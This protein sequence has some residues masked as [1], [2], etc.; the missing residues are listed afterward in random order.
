MTSD[1]HD[2]DFCGPSMH[3]FA[4]SQLVKLKNVLFNLNSE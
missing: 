4:A 1:C 3:P 2:A